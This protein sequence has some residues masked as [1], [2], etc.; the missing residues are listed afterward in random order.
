MNVLTDYVVECEAWAFT[1][2][3]KTFSYDNV[4]SAFCGLRPDATSEVA[5][6]VRRGLILGFVVGGWNLNTRLPVKALNFSSA[7]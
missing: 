5:Y 7:G 3:L 4:V 6:F 2:P 1:F